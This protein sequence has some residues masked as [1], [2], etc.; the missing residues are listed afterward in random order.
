MEVRHVD[1]PSEALQLA[2]DLLHRALVVCDPHRNRMH[3]AGEVVADYGIAAA[4]PFLFQLGELAADAVL[5]VGG[6]G[7]LEDDGHV[8]AVEEAGVGDDAGIVD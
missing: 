5:L 4:L 1:G 2:H 8:G 7:A 3:D 6:V